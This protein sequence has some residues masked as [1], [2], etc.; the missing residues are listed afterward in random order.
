MVAERF[1]HITG[2]NIKLAFPYPMSTERYFAENVPGLIK[3]YQHWYDEMKRQEDAFREA[4]KRDDAPGRRF[5]FSRFLDLAVRDRLPKESTAI[6]SIFDIWSGEVREMIWFEIRCELEKQGL[7]PREIANRH[8][9]FHTLWTPT[10]G[11]DDIQELIIMPLTLF[12]PQC[13]AAV[14]N[15]QLGVMTVVDP[16]DHAVAVSADE[17]PTTADRAWRLLQ[18]V[19]AMPDTSGLS[20]TTSLR[21]HLT[22]SPKGLLA[23]IVDTVFGSVDADEAHPNADHSELHELLEAGRSK[24]S[25]TRN[26]NRAYEAYAVQATHTARN[27]L[28]QVDLTGAW[29]WKILLL[30]AVIE[31]QAHGLD[32]V[33]E[34]PDAFTGRRPTDRIIVSLLEKAKSAAPDQV[35]EWIHGLQSA[36]HGKSLMGLLSGLPKAEEVC[37]LEMRAALLARGGAEGAR[38]ARELTEAVRALPEGAISR[39]QILACCGLALERGILSEFGGEFDGEAYDLLALLAGREPLVYRRLE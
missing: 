23:R 26:M 13:S 24:T 30:R 10:E 29:A 38:T 3:N 15:R 37:S 25:V 27:A 2:E 7:D 22:K 18:E 6:N 31:C 28:S 4:Y 35:T 16:T 39:A 11:G 19:A 20:F 1:D 32:F 17:D 8:T 9:F 34:L 33:E 21:Q 5:A 14:F 12:D 36:G